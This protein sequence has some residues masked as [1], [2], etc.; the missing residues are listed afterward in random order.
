MSMSLDEYLEM[1]RKKF[2]KKDADMI[3]MLID[4]IFWRESDSV[5]ARYT[6]TSPKLIKK[7][8]AQVTEDN[9]KDYFTI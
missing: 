9:K 4:G 3:E 5:I 7:I 2:P 8:R 6:R 1:I